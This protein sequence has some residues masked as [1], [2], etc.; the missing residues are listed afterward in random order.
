MQNL[1]LKTMSKCTSSAIL[2]EDK[3]LYFAWF[4]RCIFC[5]FY[6]PLR[7]NHS[8]WHGTPDVVLRMNDQVSSCKLWKHLCLMISWHLVCCKVVPKNDSNECSAQVTS[9]LQLH[10]SLPYHLLIWLMEWNDEI[11][12]VE[13]AL[14]LLCPCCIVWSKDG[15]RILISS[16]KNHV[17]SLSFKSMRT[18]IH[19][20]Y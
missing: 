20:H 19:I 12:L 7:G 9:A 5:L 11:S 16:P 17:W 13:Q 15:H 4:N 14:C 3:S 10:L 6:I 8:L 2:H 18:F 1:K